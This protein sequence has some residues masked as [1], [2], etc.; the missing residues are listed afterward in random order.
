MNMPVRRA[1][2]LVTM[3][4]NAAE[5]LPMPVPKSKSLVSKFLPFVREVAARVIPPLVTLALILLVWQL[6]TDN[7][8]ASLPSPLKIWH[9]AKD[10]IIDPFFVAGPQDIGLGFR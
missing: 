7:P 10:L 9:E 3:P 1:E 6:L 4:G 5:V 2:K 8:K